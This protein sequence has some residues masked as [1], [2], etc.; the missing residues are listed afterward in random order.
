MKT[1][2]T[3]SYFASGFSLDFLEDQNFPLKKSSVCIFFLHNFSVFFVPF[4]V[5]PS[6]LLSP[7]PNEVPFR[8][9]CVCWVERA[10]RTPTFVAATCTAAG[11]RRSRRSRR[12]RK[13][14]RKGLK[15]E[16]EE[17]RKGKE[18]GK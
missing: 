8:A 18:K 11:M 16:K 3:S 9:L 7:L 6:L 17:N 4:A 1:L 12:K 13:G 5:L 2:S 15:R 10:P 14:K